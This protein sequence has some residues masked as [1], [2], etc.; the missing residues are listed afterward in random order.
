VNQRALIVAIVIAVIASLTMADQQLLQDIRLTQPHDK[1]H[2]ADFTPKFAD[3]AAWEHRADFLRH[4]ALVSQGLWPMPEKTPLNPV[5]HGK[6]DRD[7][8]TIEKV[9]FASM[10]GHYVSGNLYRPKGKTGPLPAVLSPYGHWPDGRFIWK[11]DKAIQKEID[12]GAEVDRIA[13]KTPL[14]ANCAMLARMGCIVFQYDMVGYCDSQKIPHRQGFTD[15]EAMLR[16][17]SFM[18]LQTW[19]SIRS[20]DFILSLPDVDPNRIGVTGSSSGGMQTMALNACDPRATVAVPIVM[21]SMAMQGGCVCETAPLFRVETNNVEI[22]TLFAPKPEGMASANDWTK[23]FMTHGLPEMKSIWGLYDAANEVDGAHFEFGHNHNLHSREYEYNFVN[24]HLK[25]GWPAPVKEAAFEPVEP[26]DLSVYDKDHPLP[27]DALDAAALRREMTR[28]SDEQLDRQARTGELPATLRVAMNAML[29]DQMPTPSDVEATS[30]HAGFGGTPTT[31]I[32]PDLTAGSG[33]SGV[34]SEPGVAR[35]AGEWTGFIARKNSGEHVPA[36]ALFPNNWNGTVVIYATPRGCAALGDANS[37][38]RRATD[39]GA[40]VLAVDV[41]Q[42]GTFKREPALAPVAAPSTKPN[43]NPP[44]AGYVNGYNRTTIAERTH[45]LLTAI[46]VARGWTGTRS[47]AL[48]G[49]DGAGPW[50][51]L[52]RAMAGDR[53]DRAAIDLAGFDFSAVHDPADPL[54][55]PGALKY[56]GVMGLASL[57]DHGPTLL[58][59]APGVAVRMPPVPNP[60]LKIRTGSESV[61]S[62]LDTLVTQ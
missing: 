35:T 2:P 12:S 5:I 51:L 22:A 14:Q 39:S 11:D 17:Q 34:P 27:G 4:Q 60:Q 29:V 57:C 7:A 23:T 8:Y 26:K 53:I 42:S 50:A 47:V 61:Q 52:A 13:A 6:I 45:D 16:L 21:V 24:E 31:R 62:M 44:Y 28:T 10:P 55:L 56:G 41:F 54:L 32:S 18:G 37:D 58:C 19:N 46:T 1:D 15:A 49:T 3:R 33:S 43:P 59:F 9:F 40:A 30:D 38:A 48:L 25:L 36:R 20:M